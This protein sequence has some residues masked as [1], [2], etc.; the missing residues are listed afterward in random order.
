MKFDYSMPIWV[1]IF[2]GTQL[3]TGTRAIFR[4]RDPLPNA[5]T[6]DALKSLVQH[7]AAALRNCVRRADVLEALASGD[8]LAS[9]FSDSERETLRLLE[10]ALRPMTARELARRRAALPLVTMP[11]RDGE[12]RRGI[13]RGIV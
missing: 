10:E 7:E 2:I 11:T 9:M 8:F 5:A 12:R 1:S 3:P 13:S 4:R 6:R